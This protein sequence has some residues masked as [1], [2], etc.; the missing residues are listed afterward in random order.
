MMLVGT[1]IY[2]VEKAWKK[3]NIMRK[4]KFALDRRSLEVIYTSFNRPGLEYADV[5]WCNLSNYDSDKLDKIQ[6]ECAR[7]VTGATRLVSLQRLQQECNWESL[8]VR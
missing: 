1:N 7:I 6:N 8:T 2:I 5:V 3:V 4:L